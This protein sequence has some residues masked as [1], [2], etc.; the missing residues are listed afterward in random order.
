MQPKVMTIPKCTGEPPR[1]F[2]IGRNS[3][4]MMRDDSAESKNI[5]AD[6]HNAD[7]NEHNKFLYWF[8]EDEAWT[9]AVVWLIVRSLPSAMASLL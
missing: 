3:G 8:S 6:K 4:V 7:N 1:V 9:C 5:P 2:S